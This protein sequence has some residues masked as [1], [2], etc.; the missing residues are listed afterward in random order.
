[1]KKINLFFL[2]TSLIGLISSTA[3]ANS[4]P[5]PAAAAPSTPAPAVGAPFTGFFAGAQGGYAYGIVDA[6]CIDIA[7]RATSFDRYNLNGVSGGA[8]LG[9]GFQTSNCWYLGFEVTA[10]QYVLKNKNDTGNAEDFFKQKASHSFGLN[11]RLG[12]TVNGSNL[13]YIKLG[14]EFTKW[15]HTINHNLVN[16]HYSK[17]KVLPGFAPGIGFAVLVTPHVLVGLEGSY[18]FYKKAPKVR[19]LIGMDHSYRDKI[20]NFNLRVSYKF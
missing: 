11:P 15:N 9:Y 3:F 18:V 16:R 14:V 19:N 20:A 1:M 4:G 12:F 5:L 2:S 8:H 6:P 10:N 13:I 7:T 17:T